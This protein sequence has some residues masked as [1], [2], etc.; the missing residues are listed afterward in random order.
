MKEKVETGESIV[1]KQKQLRRKLTFLFRHTYEQ[2]LSLSQLKMKPKRFNNNRPCLFSFA[3]NMNQTVNTDRAKQLFVLDS[4]SFTL[5]FNKQG[6][7]RK[8]K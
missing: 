2:I 3:R 8:N 7:T 6:R 5:G 4:A 1:C